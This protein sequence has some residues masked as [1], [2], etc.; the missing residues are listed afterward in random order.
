MRNMSTEPIISSESISKS[1]E[2]EYKAEIEKIL[3]M[4]EIKKETRQ[5]LI[6]TVVSDKAS[7]SIVVRV[8]HDRF[9]PKYQRFYSVHKKFMAHDEKEEASIGDKVRIVPCR[10]MSR[11]KRH[12]LYEILSTVPK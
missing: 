7:K 10:P 12:A 6:G 8:V 4:R 3:Q 5:F 9:I 2:E 1:D 11:K